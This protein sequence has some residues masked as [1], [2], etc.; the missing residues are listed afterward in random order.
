[1]LRLR[2]LVAS[3]DGARTVRGELEVDAGAAVSGGRRLAEQ[4]LESGGDAILDE[5]RAEQEP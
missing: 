5:I 3:P 1:M 4:I 2:G